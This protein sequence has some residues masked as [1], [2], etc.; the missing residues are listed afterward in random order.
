MIEAALLRAISRIADDA[1][2]VIGHDKYCAE[3]REGVIAEYSED[4]SEWRG[5]G[6]GE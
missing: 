1:I 6:L 5:T 3:L 4:N 2:L